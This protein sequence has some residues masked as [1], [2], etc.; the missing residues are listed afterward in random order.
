MIAAGLMQLRAGI[1]GTA[2]SPYVIALLGVRRGP[3]ARQ[4]RWRYFVP[5]PLLLPAS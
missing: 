3:D 2:F 1:F 4:K 5:V